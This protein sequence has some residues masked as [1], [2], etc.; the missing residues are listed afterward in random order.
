M[1]QRMDEHRR[2]R[3]AGEEQHDVEGIHWES[4]LTITGTGRLSAWPHHAAL[5]ALKNESLSLC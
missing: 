2:Q 5:S 3:T 4:P 1:L